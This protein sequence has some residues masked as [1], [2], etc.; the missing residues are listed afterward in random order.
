M[1]I[2]DFD[3][4]LFDM[5]GT[6]YRERHALPGVATLFDDIRCA[7]KTIRC[8]TNNSAN[9]AQE[10]SDRL[11]VMGVGVPP[12]WIY[13][14]C[15]GMAEVIRE[16]KPGNRIIRV[17]NFAGSALPVELAGDAEF[18]ESMTASCDV[19][20]VG[21][22]MRENA[23]AFDFERSLVGLNLLRSGAELVVGCRDRV[24]P[25]HG[26]GVE[27]GSGSWATLFAFGGNVPLERVRFAGKPEPA[28]FQKLCLR[29]NAD[30][31][32][33]LVVGDNLESDIQG[34]LA[35]GMTTALVLTGVTRR[36]DLAT[37]A[38]QPHVVFDDLVAMRNAIAK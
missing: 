18:V 17:F 25:I 38:I 5:D 31:R 33:C 23:V 11:R 13:T 15:H 26:G 36:E 29:I 34:G 22:H 14:A 19:V 28:F 9:T 8:V 16:L 2:T 10:L 20:A 21:T 1:R 4:V 7:N 37:S 30:P 27:F 6:L 24:F 32:R 12:E 35:V 3:A